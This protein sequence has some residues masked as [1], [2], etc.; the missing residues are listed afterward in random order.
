MLSPAP[1]IEPIKL[2]AKVVQREMGIDD[3][4]IMLG[5]ENWEIPK[6]AGLYIA[7]AYGPDDTLSS[8]SQNSTDDQGNYTEVQEA[9]MLHH[10]DLDVMSF[11]SEA[12]LRKEAV[13]WALAS[14]Y[15]QEQQEVYGMRINQIPGSF[16]P[17]PS[18]EETKQLNRFRI[19]FAVN[20]LHRNIKITPY[21]DTVN[22]PEVTYN[23]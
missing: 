22:P 3:G 9:V 5:L 21:Y 1:L 2:V 16:I 14:A 18:L 12:R 11:N 7:L 13:L 20:A 10:I 4:S 23:A 17:T 15:S 8:T 19:S 6:T